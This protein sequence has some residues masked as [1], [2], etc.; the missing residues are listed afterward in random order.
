MTKYN[1]TYHTRDTNNNQQIEV[2]D[3]YLKN[4]FDIDATMFN[5][6]G[7]TSLTL[8]I[9]DDDNPRAIVITRAK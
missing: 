5:R 9:D 2:D 6:L 7:L 3:R 1:L 4:M 8:K